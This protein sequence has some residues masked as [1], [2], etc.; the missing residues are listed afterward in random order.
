MIWYS[1]SFTC[2]PRRRWQLDFLHEVKAFGKMP[3]EITTQWC[4]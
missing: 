2:V 1:L 3:E 4:C